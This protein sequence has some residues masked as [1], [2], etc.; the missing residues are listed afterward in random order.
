MENSNNRRL[1]NIAAAVV[2]GLVTGWLVSNLRAAAAAPNIEDAYMFAR[3]AF[4]VRHKLGLS[5]NADGVHTYGQTSLLWCGVVTM[6]SYLPSGVGQVLVLGSWLSSL[7]A[8]IALAWAVSA[9][10][11]SSLLS[12]TWRVLPLVALPLAATQVFLNNAVNGMET[13]LAAALCAVFVGLG[14]K[15]QRG[16]VRPEIVG[17]VGFLLFLTR[18]ES[19]VVVVL[20]PLLLFLL[21]HG[22]SARSLARLLGSFIACVLLEMLICKLYF[23]S[24]LPLSF[25]M[26]SLHLYEGYVNVPDWYP[27]LKMFAFLDACELFLVTLVF[28]SR[29]RDWRLLVCCLTPAVTAF[30]YLQ[31]VMQIS[32]GD[33][34]YYVPYFAL[35]IVPALL[36]ADEWFAPAVRAVGSAPIETPRNEPIEDPWPG[37]ALLFRS[38]IAGAVMFFCFALSTGARLT[39]L[40]RR[41]DKTVHYGYDPVKLDIAANVPLPQM[42][43]FA[44]VHEVTDLLIAP[45]PSGVT[46]A[47]SEV[48]YMGSSAQQINIIDLAGLNDSEIAL[49][50]FSRSSLLAR[51]PDIIWMPCF[52]Y[53]Y[54][55]GVMMSD[56]RLL[57]QYDFYADAGGYGVAIRKDSPYRD[58]IDHQM[59]VFWSATY[60]GYKMSD[61]LV[62]SSSW[63]GAKHQVF[64]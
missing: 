53:T 16:A 50:G 17:L 46:V 64:D 35:F 14:L 58:P 22:V 57:E 33:A 5:W 4:N 34:R 51:K 28:L 25:Y 49:H 61:Y 38:C 27:E 24:A 1:Y 9:N 13:M 36:V 63:S 18:P 29:K 26:K 21:M 6:L 45:L 54:Q 52:P 39:T 32:G 19:A 20:F 3:Y 31:T 2:V 62:R 11:K 7:G 47:A 8:L 10:A 40:I 42:G 23:R 12:S 43:W 48:G 59:Q 15:W 55:R 37:N 56:P 30:I 41:A 60:P 44:T